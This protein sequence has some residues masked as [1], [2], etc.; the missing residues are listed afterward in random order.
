[1]EKLSDLEFVFN[2][3]NALEKQEL[4]KLVFD[5]NLYY[6]EGMYRTPTMIDLLAHNGSILKVVGRVNNFVLCIL[7]KDRCKRV[8]EIF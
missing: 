5:Q 1:M 7:R 3:T 8:T 6:Q 2:K 4:I